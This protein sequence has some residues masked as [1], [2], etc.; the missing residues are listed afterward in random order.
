LLPHHTSSAN[1]GRVLSGAGL[2][3]G[4][5]EN[6]KGVSSSQ[7][8]DDFKGVPDDSDGFHLLTSVSSV[9]L[10]GS[11]ESLNDRAQCLSEL[12]G[13]VSSSSVGH[14]HLG[15]G[16]GGS[17][18]VDEARVCNLSRQ[19]LTLISSYDHLEKSLGAFSNPI[20]V[21]LS[22]SRVAFSCL[23]TTFDMW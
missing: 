23:A 7:E 8:M 6:L 18:I 16:G 22:S 11:D 9:E 21:L 10:K 12:L 2:D 3:D 4:V 13:L 1:S 19:S 20:L 15:L 5:D 14:E 17:D